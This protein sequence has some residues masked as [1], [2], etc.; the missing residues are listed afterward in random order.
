[1]TKVSTIVVGESLDTFASLA[2]H[3]LAQ[4]L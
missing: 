1:L 2:R 3:S 4:L